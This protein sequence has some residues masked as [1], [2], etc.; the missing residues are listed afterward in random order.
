M[1]EM[2]T[3]DHIQLLEL[4]DRYLKAHEAVVANEGKNQGLKDVRHMASD[5]L[6]REFRSQMVSLTKWREAQKGKQVDMFKT[7][8]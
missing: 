1:P 5:K 4:I 6:E 7:G 8:K 2:Y 3:P